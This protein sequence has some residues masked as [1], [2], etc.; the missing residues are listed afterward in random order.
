MSTNR[1]AAPCS[2]CGGLVPANGGRLSKRGRVWLVSHLS[3]A[4][5]GQPEVITFTFSSGQTA[6]QNRRGRCIDA[7]C[8]GCCTI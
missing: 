8:C 5:S 4:D 2:I 3:C 6:I 1:Y 7:P